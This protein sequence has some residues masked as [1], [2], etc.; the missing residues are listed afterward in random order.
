MD[1]TLSAINLDGALING[2]DAATT[3]YDVTIAANTTSVN[4]TATANDAQASVAI[5][6]GGTID[7]TS[8]SETVTITVTAED[9]TEMTYT[10]NITVEVLSD[11]ATLSAINIDGVLITDFDPATTSYDVTIAANTSSVSITAT[12][13]D[14]KASVAITNSG[15]ID[16]TSGGATATITVTAEDGTVM[17]YTVNITVLSDDA[18]LSAINLDG[19]LISGFDAA[20]TSYDVTVAA[21]TS[22]VSITATANDAQASVAITNGGTIDVT[23]G[24][25]TVTITVIAEDGTE[26]T[27]TINIT[28][29][30]ATS[31]GK[32]KEANIKVYPT[33]TTSVITVEFIEEPGKINILQLVRSVDKKFSS[34]F[35]N[36]NN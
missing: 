1:A 6:N 20:T 34:H 15:S 9:G 35:F 32:L 11:D 18:T 28:V 29:E 21:N 30:T 23:S 36:R 13:N 24:S 5:T 4:I 16:V 7:V 27:Y 26:M 19:S 31:I 3:T 14:A 2:F 8:G 10:I 12:A 25:E 17:T 33:I 22:N